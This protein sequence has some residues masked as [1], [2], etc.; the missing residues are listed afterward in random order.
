MPLIL[1]RRAW[2][3]ESASKTFLHALAALSRDG[4]RFR[5]VL[6]GGGPTLPATRALASK[7]DLVGCVELTGPLT[8]EEVRGLLHQAT[9][10]CLPSAWEGMPGTL[11]EA[12]ATGVAVVATNVSGTN[13]LVVQGSRGFWYL[14]YDPPALARAL[15]ALLDDRQARARLAAGARRRIEEC[16]ALDVMLGAKQ[17]LYRE[18]SGRFPRRERESAE[19]IP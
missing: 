5:A 3:N 6:A 9:I 18:V 12:M 4:H 14:F 8:P 13:D 11:M 15:A 2:W 7:L 16:F 10:A 19:G 17:R 1:S